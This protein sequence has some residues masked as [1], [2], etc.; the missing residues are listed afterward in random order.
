MEKIN[1]LLVFMEGVLSFFSP[2]V[3]PILLV[4]LGI[5]SSSSIE[6]LKSKGH[7]FKNSNLFKNE[8]LNQKGF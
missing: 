6:N 2:C 8:V 5:L 1:L 3:L 4:Y 7:N